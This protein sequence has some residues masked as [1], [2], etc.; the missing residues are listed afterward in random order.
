VMD[1]NTVGSSGRTP[2][3]RFATSRASP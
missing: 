3:N 2:R 1:A